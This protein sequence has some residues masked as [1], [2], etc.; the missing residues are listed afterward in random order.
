M[1]RAPTKPV[2]QHRGMENSSD[3]ARR[4]ENLIRP[5][6][7]SAVTYEP[8]RC[9]VKTGGLE[10]DWLP[11]FASRSGKTSTWSPADEGEP[12]IVFCPSGD[13]ATGFVLLGMNSSD[14]PAPSVS[15]DENVAKFADG[16]TVRH[17]AAEGV[18][19]LKLKKLV[20]D[21][22]G[23]IEINGTVI[24]LKGAKINLNGG[25]KPSARVG[26]QVST[27]LKIVSGSSTVFVGD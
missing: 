22:S 13:P 25:G 1:P 3:L 8:P 4:L 5:G 16:T 23:P 7:V 15:P 17:N 27:D 21:C 2:R 6:R 12:C 10:T 19:E 18:L 20:I 9:R 14:S 26:D 11:W 24:D